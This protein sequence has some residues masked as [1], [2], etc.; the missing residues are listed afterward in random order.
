MLRLLIGQPTV[1]L[2]DEPSNDLDIETLEW[3]E[4]LINGWPYIVLYIS[5]DE[6]LIENTATM[7]IH[8]EQ[9]RRK[10][11]S[12]YTIANMPYL[13]YKEER[14]AKFEKQEQQALND[15]REK[16]IRD[17]KFRKIYQRVDHE[18]AAVSRQ[19]PAG[20]RLLKK[21]CTRCRH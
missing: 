11:L 15:R 8:L 9:I 13:Q 1:L 5:H 7:V 20:G 19:D 10:T 17:E 18:Q 21:K 16:Q 12:R 14:L 4:T 3:L 6:T 2:L